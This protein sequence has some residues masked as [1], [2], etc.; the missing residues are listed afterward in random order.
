MDKIKIIY[1]ETPDISNVELRKKAELSNINNVKSEIS[2]IKKDIESIRNGMSILNIEVVK[3]VKNSNVIEKDD[4][5]SVKEDIQLLKTEIDILKT[6][7]TKF[8]N[9]AEYAK[10]RI[11][12]IN[13]ELIVAG[14]F[15]K[16]GE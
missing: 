6:D 3:D 15:F 1:N 9:M 2:E 10:K 14:I 13:R 4:I 8:K 12:E 5:V 7:F 11:D 16:E